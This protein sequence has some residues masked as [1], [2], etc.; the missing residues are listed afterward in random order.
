MTLSTTAQ[1]IF[2]AAVNTG[3]GDT[4]LDARP[5]SSP[6]PRTPLSGAYTGAVTIAARRIGPMTALAASLL[7]TGRALSCCVPSCSCGDLRARS[8][9]MPRQSGNP[10]SSGTSSTPLAS[11]A[12]A[13]TGAVIVSN[14][15]TAAGV[16]KLYAV[17][18]TTGRHDRHGLRDERQAEAH[19]YLGHPRR[20]RT[21]RLACRHAP[22]GRL[23]RP[24]ARRPGARPVGRRASSPRRRTRRRHRSRRS[25]RRA[26]ASTCA[27]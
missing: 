5:S 1:K 18:G 19:R 3:D 12:D 14:A 22:A 11:R 17:D 23:H 8:S 10:R 25:A 7:V 4:T 21:L 26:C 2:N 13:V 9:G 27:T 24:R 15:G 16:V 6:T 20:R